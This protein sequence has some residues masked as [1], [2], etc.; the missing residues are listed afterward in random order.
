MSAEK[1]RR[2]PERESEHEPEHEHAA[3]DEPARV[4]SDE[5]NAPGPV[6]RDDAAEALV[7]GMSDVLGAA[8][9][10]GASVARAVAQ[11]TAG[12]KGVEPP[13]SDRSLEAMVHYSLATVTNVL[14]IVTGAAG[15]GVRA[16]PTGS[17]AAD[18]AGARPATSARNAGETAGADAAP[19][20]TVRAGHALRVPLSIQ[21]PGAEPMRGIAPVCLALEARGLGAGRPLG[22]AALRFQP[23]S[24]DVAPRDFE[25]LTVFVDTEPDT[26]PGRYEAVIGLGAPG[27]ETRLAF[28]VAAA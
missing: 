16:A 19:L 8:L 20:P 14:G 28:Q 24:L 27:V 7:R 21:N 23:A 1:R 26:A 18:A 22:A 2:Q 11:A 17:G 5:P 4:R 15:L 25:K 9:G 3:D 10:V 6:S 13:R 12:S